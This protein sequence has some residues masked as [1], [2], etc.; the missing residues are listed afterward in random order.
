MPVLILASLVAIFLASPCCA[1]ILPGDD[2]HGLPP[3]ANTALGAV[4]FQVALG[5]L[6]VT[7]DSRMA[8][9]APFQFCKI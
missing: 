7:V 9:L 6:P 4:V 3:T 1:A 8:E 5:I 2:V